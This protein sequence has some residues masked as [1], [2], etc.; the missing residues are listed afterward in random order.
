MIYEYKMENV[1]EIIRDDD[2]P[3]NMF[4]IFPYKIVFTNGNSLLCN[5]YEIDPE[6]MVIRVY[7]ATISCKDTMLLSTIDENK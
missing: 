1:K 3:A 5:K 2:Y 7:K 4:V 6:K